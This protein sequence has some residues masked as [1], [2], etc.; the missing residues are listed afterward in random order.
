MKITNDPVLIIFHTLQ[1][2]TTG[3]GQPLAE[4]RRTDVS[5]TEGFGQSSSDCATAAEQ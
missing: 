5:G 1:N 3:D 4:K 2:R